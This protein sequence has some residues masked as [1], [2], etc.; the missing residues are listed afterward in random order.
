MSDERVVSALDIGSNTIRLYVGR[1]TGDTLTPLDDESVFVR[2]G[3]D[4]D[5]TGLLRPD[6]EERALEA[7]SHLAAV[8]RDL[9]AERPIAVATSAV[10]DARNGAEFVQRVERETGIAVEILSGEREAELTF[11]GATVGNTPTRETVVVDLGG[12]SAEVIAADAAGMEWAVSLPLGSGRLSERYIA[13]DPPQPEEMARLRAGIRETL[14]GLPKIAPRV[15]IFTGGTATHMT[16]LLGRRGTWVQLERHDLDT[17][18]SIVC[19]E[20]AAEVVSRYSLDPER[21]RVLPAGFGALQTIAAYYD[22]PAVT[23]ARSGIREGV[24]LEAVRRGASA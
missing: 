15:G 16:L 22:L 23:V 6:R 7:I 13:H 20:T 18:L 4:V 24:V 10:R 1:I 8:A 11:L 12:G 17:V 3:A 9:G 14:D 19:T 21:A 5:K 2:L